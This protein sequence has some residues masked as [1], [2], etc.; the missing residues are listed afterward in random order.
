MITPWT[1]PWFYTTRNVNLQAGPF[2]FLGLMLCWDNLRIYVL[3]TESYHLQLLRQCHTAHMFSYITLNWFYCLSIIINFIQCHLK[4][5]YSFEVAVSFV[6]HP[7]ANWPSKP[8]SHNLYSWKE[9]LKDDFWFV[10]YEKQN[11]WHS[12]KE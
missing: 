9:L 2:S 7:Y 3:N 5:P 6:I 4:E 8:C 1:G 10:W 11:S 12:W